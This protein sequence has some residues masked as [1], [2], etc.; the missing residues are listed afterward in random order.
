MEL[1]VKQAVNVPADILRLLADDLAL[2]KLV[3]FLRRTYIA[4][5]EEKN[6]EHGKYTVKE[7]Q[8]RVIA[9]HFIVNA[10]FLVPE[11]IGFNAAYITAAEEVFKA[12]DKI[13]S[14]EEKHIENK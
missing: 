3:A 14:T 12:I 1:T 8:K 7:D 6:H 11:I 10:L 9:D 13:K 5:D 4:N 2:F